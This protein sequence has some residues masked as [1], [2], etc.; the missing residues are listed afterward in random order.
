M[1]QGIAWF[2]SCQVIPM[3]KEFCFYGTQKIHLLLYQHKIKMLTKL[4]KLYLKDV[5]K[6]RNLKQQQALTHTDPNSHNLKL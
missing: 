4:A 5:F 1:V 6:R 2:I 3:L